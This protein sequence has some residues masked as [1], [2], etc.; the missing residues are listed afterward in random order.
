[1]EPATAPR[2]DA[3]VA[4]AVDRRDVPLERF[5]C[6]VEEGRRRIGGCVRDCCVDGR[7]TGVLDRDPVLLDIVHGGPREGWGLDSRV[8]GWRQERRQVTDVDEP[9]GVEGLEFGEDTDDVTGIVDR[10]ELPIEF[11]AVARGSPVAATGLAAGALGANVRSQLRPVR[12]ADIVGAG[13]EELVVTD[14][15]LVVGCERHGGPLQRG[16]PDKGRSA[17]VVERCGLVRVLRPVAGELPLRRPAAVV[18]R[19]PCVLG[20]DAPEIRTVVEVDWWVVLRALDVDVDDD[21]V[22]PVAIR[23]DLELVRLGANHGRPAEGDVADWR[24]DGVRRRQER[25]DC[26]P[27]VRV[28]ARDRPFADDATRARSR[29]ESPPERLVDRGR[30]RQGEVRVVRR[31]GRREDELV[32]VIDFEGVALGARERL[33]VEEDGL[34][35]EVEGVPV[36]RRIDD[37]RG[38]PLL[39]ER[40]HR[41]ERSNSGAAVRPGDAPVEEAQRQVGRRRGL[42]VN[43]V[44]VVDERGHVKFG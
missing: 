39:G 5:V 2:R 9:P 37:G 32:V 24:S 29:P 22:V 10:S 25:R 21:I 40:A 4:E 30:L 26:R 15:H 33:P 11:R 28:L 17:A 13:R 27:G 44:H 23:A 31:E 36:G 41:R 16:H 8:V 43:G 42:T 18:G 35:R 1:M 34:G 6:L 38:A 20:P 12:H 14:P 7:P 19:A 3:R